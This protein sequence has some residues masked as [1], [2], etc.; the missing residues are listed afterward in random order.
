M[1]EA[2]KIFYPQI[3]PLHYLRQE[4]RVFKKVSA[5]PYMF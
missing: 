1:E 2:G 4:R 5:L 3:Q